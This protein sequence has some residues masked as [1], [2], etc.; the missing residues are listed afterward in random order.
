MT[1]DQ[2]DRKWRAGVELAQ[3]INREFRTGRA[4]RPG[5]EVERW[6][7]VCRTCGQFRANGCAELELRAATDDETPEYH[8]LLTRSDLFC[9]RWRIGHR[10]GPI[11]GPKRDGPGRHG[12]TTSSVTAAGE[13]AVEK[14][15]RAGTKRTQDERR[16][17]RRA[18]RRRRHKAG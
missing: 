6:L 12:V 1:T 17:A 18:G 11:E 9:R 16:A 4:T 8:E 5:L 2:A 3:K 10:P 13:D 14:V 15:H 7:A